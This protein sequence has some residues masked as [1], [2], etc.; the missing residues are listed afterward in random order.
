VA[1]TQRMPNHPDPPSLT[2]A[3]A[4]WNLLE[5]SGAMVSDQNAALEIAQHVVNAQYAEAVLG[6]TRRAEQAE[7][8]AVTSAT[9]AS[10]RSS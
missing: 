7:R 5:D 4:I 2:L 6:P 9:A 3:R 8:R 1:Y 10:P